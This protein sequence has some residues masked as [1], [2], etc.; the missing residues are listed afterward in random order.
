MILLS[1]SLISF[2]SLSIHWVSKGG[3]SEMCCVVGGNSW[4]PVSAD[5]RF[6][7]CCSRVFSAVVCSCHPVGS[8]VLP[9]SS[10]T[11]CDPSNGDCPCK[12]G[13]AGPHCE[14]CMVGYWGFGDYGCRPCDCAGSCDPHTGDCL[15]R[16]TSVAL[17][18]ISVFQFLLKIWWWSGKPR[19]PLEEQRCSFTSL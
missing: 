6:T 16:W 5:G 13:V 17:A 18:L 4:G 2:R 19:M 9:F 3:A 10:V 1:C 14:R 15:S 11:F 8:A 12:P 7:H